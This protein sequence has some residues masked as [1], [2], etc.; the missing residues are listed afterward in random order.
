MEPTSKNLAVLTSLRER[1]ARRRSEPRKTKK[2]DLFAVA[3]ACVD[4][5]TANTADSTS[6]GS[7]WR[8]FT[9][10]VW[11]AIRNTF[12]RERTR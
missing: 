9:A 6:H 10:R 4:G 1:S 2:S 11:A 7:K 12:E 3:I 5:R 8:I